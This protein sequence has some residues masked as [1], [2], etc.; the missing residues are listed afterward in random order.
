MSGVLWWWNISMKYM[1]GI[2]RALWLISLGIPKYSF[3]SFQKSNTHCVFFH[4]SHKIE[5]KTDINME[6]I[7]A[8][9]GTIMVPVA[10][11]SQKWWQLHPRER[12]ARQSWGIWLANL[13]ATF[14]HQVSDSALTNIVENNQGRLPVSAWSLPTDTYTW[15]HAFKLICAHETY[16]IYMYMGNNMLYIYEYRQKLSFSKIW[17]IFLYYF[18]NKAFASSFL[19]LYKIIS[20]QDR[21]QQ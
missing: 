2:C 15:A 1:P 18:W 3:S 17:K 13:V 11:N 5:V 16:N 9:S 6:N 12:E 21:K 10:Q 19:V 8:V 7:K 4:T 14:A 20:E